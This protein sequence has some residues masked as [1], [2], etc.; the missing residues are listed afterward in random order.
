MR[1]DLWVGHVL[2]FVGKVLIKICLEVDLKR[3]IK[4]VV[5]LCLV[6]GDWIWTLI[7]DPIKWMEI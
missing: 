1:E 4:L 7:S 3:V 6:F 5:V 2:D